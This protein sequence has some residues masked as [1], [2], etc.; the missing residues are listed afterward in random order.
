MHPTA[1]WL[2]TVGLALFLSAC[3]TRTPVTQPV[4]AQTEPTP[5]KETP[6]NASAGDSTFKPQ[7]VIMPDESLEKDLLK[8]SYSVK[9]LTD[10]ENTFLLSLTFRNKKDKNVV[11]HPRIVLTDKTGNQ[12]HAYSQKAFIRLTKQQFGHSPQA[13]EKTKWAKSYWLKERFTVPANGID[14]GELVFHCKPACQP[15]QL[16]VQLDKQTFSFTLNDN[17]L[18]P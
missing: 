13:D 14:I 7:R 10:Y 9:P 3:A 18:I 6:A 2:T 1:Q 5:V 17:Y 4:P 16:S 12:I 11:M 15:K 8:I